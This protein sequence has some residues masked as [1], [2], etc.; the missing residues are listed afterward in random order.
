[1]RLRCWSEAGH[2]ALDMRK[3]IEQSCNPYFCNLGLSVGYPRMRALAERFGFGSRTGIALPAETPGLLPDEAWKRRMLRDAWRPGDTA[4]IAVG[5]GTLLVSPL[6]MAVYAAAL[7]TGGT[8]WQPRLVLEPAD[9]SGPWRPVRRMAWSQATLDTVRG[10]LRDVVE[11]PSG[12]GKRARVPG[13]V[14]GGKTG[15]AEYGPAGRR[16]KY[17]WMIA[18]A[19][20]D[21]PSAA[22]AL[23]VEDGESGG[24][25]VAPLA[26]RLMAAIF[27]LPAAEPADAA[28]TPDAGG[29]GI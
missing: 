7:A 29:P 22:L 14:L 3:A 25:T 10:G 19:P 12:T 24:L 9:G 8:V 5:Q 21:D 26:R 23:L 17:T 28:A 11:S 16:R 13:L 27:H 15:T 18:F 6:Q 20:F 2:G 1:M 4:S